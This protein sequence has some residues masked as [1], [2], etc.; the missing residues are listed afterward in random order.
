MDV[1]AVRVAAGLRTGSSVIL[2][3]STDTSD[4]QI[5]TDLGTMT[6]LRVGDL[7]DELLERYGHVHVSSFF[8][9]TGAREHPV[10]GPQI[11]RRTLGDHG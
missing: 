2:V 1:S 4:R 7:P 10:E 9:H 11:H 3:G 8:M 5:L 6:E